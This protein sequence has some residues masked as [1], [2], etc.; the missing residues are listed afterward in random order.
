MVR[1]RG[2]APITKYMST[3]AA[4]ERKQWLFAAKYTLLLLLLL[5]LL[6]FL[7]LLMVSLETAARDRRHKREKPRA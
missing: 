5:L 1:L 2:S 6:V 3:V 7:L 4:A